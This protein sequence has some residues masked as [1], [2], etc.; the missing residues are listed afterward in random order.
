[1]SLSVTIRFPKQKNDFKRASRWVRRSMVYRPLV[2]NVT[3]DRRELTLTFAE[4]SQKNILMSILIDSLKS[5]GYEAEVLTN[6]Q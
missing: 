4:E 1:M 6:K 5:Q 3:K 2:S